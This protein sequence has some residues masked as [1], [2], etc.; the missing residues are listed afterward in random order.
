MIVASDTV[1]PNFCGSSA[2]PGAITKRTSNGIANSIA[3]VITS[4]TEKSTPNTSSEKRRAPSMPFASISLEK[5]GTKAALKAPSAKSRRN[6]L[7]N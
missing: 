1:S 6:V 5:S 3:M 2:K 4:S 7:G